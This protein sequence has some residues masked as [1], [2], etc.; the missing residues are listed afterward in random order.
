[1]TR[2]KLLS[3][4]DSNRVKAAIDQA[5]LQTSGEISVSVARLFWGDV[6]KAAWKAFAR[7]GMT[8]TKERNA[9]LIFVIPARRR[10]VVLGDS[11]IHEKVGQAFW[12]S[13]AATL[14]EHFRNGDFTSG[15]VAAI[16]SIGDQLAAHF[17]YDAGSD[18]NELSN[19]VDFG[20]QE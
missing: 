4:I 10:F 9:V 8:R 2:R 20:L 13:V 16:E 19:E 14:S 3:T 7:L 1:M 15:L 17:P 12:T 5:E 11:G 6:E 18:T